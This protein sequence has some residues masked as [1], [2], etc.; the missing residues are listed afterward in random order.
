MARRCEG[1]LA[2]RVERDILSEGSQS[3]KEGKLRQGC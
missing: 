2:I 3:V 1:E